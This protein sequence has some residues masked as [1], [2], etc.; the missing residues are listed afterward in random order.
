MLAI[1]EIQNLYKDNK[2][3][4]SILDSIIIFLITKIRILNGHRKS[5]KDLKEELNQI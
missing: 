3:K 1:L 4:Y 2:M 5:I